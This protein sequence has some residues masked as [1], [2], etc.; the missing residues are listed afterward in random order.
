MER[1]LCMYALPA[2]VQ[3]PMLLSP[4]LLTLFGSRD[5]LLACRRGGLELC[6]SGA[7]FV[8]R[9]KHVIGALPAGRRDREV[10]S[11]DPG[12]VTWRY[13]T[14]EARCRHA[15]MEVGSMELWSPGGALQA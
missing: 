9:V 13:G 6:S 14:L 4:R 11:R 12:V 2:C 15:D 5:F 7:A 8:T 10:W 1:Y 3:T